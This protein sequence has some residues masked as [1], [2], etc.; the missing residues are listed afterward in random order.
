MQSLVRDGGAISQGFPDLPMPRVTLHR[1][2]PSSFPLDYE[3]VL[4]GMISPS[5]ANGGHPL[6][7]PLSYRGIMHLLIF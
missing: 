3:Q 1:G 6:F 4:I 7:P 5:F 2:P